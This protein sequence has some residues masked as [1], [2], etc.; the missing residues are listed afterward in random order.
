MLITSMGRQNLK[1]MSITS[2]TSIRIGNLIRKY[3]LVEGK[4]HITGMLGVTLTL[5]RYAFL[6]KD[7][8]RTR[9][10]W[11]ACNCTKIVITLPTMPS[12]CV[13]YRPYR[14]A[15]GPAQVWVITV[16]INSRVHQHLTFVAYTLY[17]NATQVF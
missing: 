5:L 9:L 12:Q 13:L 16:I 1:T 6:K 2:N 14:P 4:E 15:F 7:D 10:E 17:Q 11:V 3:R 8:A